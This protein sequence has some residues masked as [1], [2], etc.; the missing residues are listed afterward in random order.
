VANIVSQRSKSNTLGQ[1]WRLANFIDAIGYPT[2]HM[3]RTY[4]V[5]KSRM[6][7]SR[8]HKVGHRQLLN[9]PQPLEGRAIDDCPLDRSEFD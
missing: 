3:A 6:T 7:G 8:V 4:A 1:N 5:F 9:A 2:C